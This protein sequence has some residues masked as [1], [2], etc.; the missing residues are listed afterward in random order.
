MLT[1]FIDLELVRIPSL[2]PGGTCNFPDPGLRL[3]RDLG[4]E[5][6]ILLRDR[7]RIRHLELRDGLDDHLRRVDD[8][9]RVCVEL[10]IDQSFLSA[11]NG[12]LS[13]QLRRAPRTPAET[14]DAQLPARW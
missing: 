3:P 2:G 12:A 8:I 10:S 1:S 4:I 11:L 9:A 5:L 6:E 7:R 14:R 13:T